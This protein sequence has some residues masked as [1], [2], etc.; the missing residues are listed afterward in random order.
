MKIKIYCLFL[1]LFFVGSCREIYLRNPFSAEP[2]IVLHPI[3][4]SDIFDVPVGSAVY[5]D[6]N[7]PATMV[8]KSGWFISD[9]YM[10]EIMKAKMAE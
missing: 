6:P 10:E 1:I 9:Y 8:E 3:L 5:T 7:R 4:K 2:P